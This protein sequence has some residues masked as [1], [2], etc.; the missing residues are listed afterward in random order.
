MAKNKFLKHGDIVEAEIEQI[1]TLKNS[2]KRVSLNFLV[3]IYY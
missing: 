1:C 2:I 3:S